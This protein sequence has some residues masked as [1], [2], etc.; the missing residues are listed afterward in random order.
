MRS[1]S[2]FYHSTIVCTTTIPSRTSLVAQEKG[3]VTDIGGALAN[4]SIVLSRSMA[5]AAQ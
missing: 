4:G 3:L 2:F 1:H 5:I